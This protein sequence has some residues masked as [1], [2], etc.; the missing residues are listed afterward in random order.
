MGGSRVHELRKFAVLPGLA[1]WPFELALDLHPA[2]TRDLELLRSG[3]WSIVDPVAG[4]PWNYQAFIQA[5]AAEFMV[6]NT[7]T[8]RRRAAG[9]ATLA[10]AIWPAASRSWL[11]TPAVHG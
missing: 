4:D 2:E 9:S 5:S 1:T 6:P 10:S 11:R 8:W 7:C 3:G